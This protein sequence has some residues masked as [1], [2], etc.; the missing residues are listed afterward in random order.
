MRRIVSLLLVLILAWSGAAGALISPEEEARLGRRILAQIRE[1]AEIL[2]DPEVTDYLESIARRLTPWVGP[3]YFPFRFYVVKNPTLNAFALPGGYIFFTSGLIEEV[4]REDE[5]AA[6]MAHEM[7]HIQARHVA[8]RMEVLKRLQLAT[9]AVTLAGLLLG[10]GKTGGALAVTS[11]SLALTRALAYSRAEEEEADRLGFEYLTRAG[12]DPGAFLSILQKIVRHRWLLTET[13]PN[14]L[15]THP[16]P[17]E[18]ITYLETLVKRYHRAH[19]S[20]SYRPTDPLY[21]RRIQVRVKV[22]THDPGL[23]VMRYREALKYSPDDPMLHYGLGMALARARFFREAIKELR[24]TVRQF[25]KKDYF[26]LDLAEVYFR[27]GYYPQAREV[28]EDYLSRHPKDTWALWILARTYQEEH[29]WKKA[30]PIFQDLAHKLDNFPDFHYYYGY[31]LSQM[32]REGEAH[33]QFA[34]YFNLQGDTR[35]ALY[36]F[37]K[38]LKFLPSDSPLR[39]KIR[40]KLQASPKS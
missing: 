5:L 28:L 22:E 10:G 27:A 21:L 29:L 39:R 36:H 25:P 20:A 40:E 13:G 8:R 34:R 2:D 31:L 19:P 11:T 6:V 26:R 1:R 3:R 14:Y 7:A 12:Y 9:G 35:V 33:Y 18:R 38:A 17:P 4:D 32:G 23:L 24:Q 30:W 37:R 15:L 16:A